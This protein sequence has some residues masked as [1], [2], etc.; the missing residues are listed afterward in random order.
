M[1]KDSSP[2]SFCFNWYNSFGDFMNDTKKGMLLYPMM[3]AFFLCKY[4]C[5]C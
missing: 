3:A 1:N 2:Y 5:F 4:E